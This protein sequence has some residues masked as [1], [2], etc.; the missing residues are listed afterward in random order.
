MHH[1]GVVFVSGPRRP[2]P[3]VTKGCKGKQTAWVINDEDRH[4]AIIFWADL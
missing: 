2:N 1:S 4:R 3:V